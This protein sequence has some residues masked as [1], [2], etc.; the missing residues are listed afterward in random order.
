MCIRD[1][2]EPER[3]APTEAQ[4]ATPPGVPVAQLQKRLALITPKMCIRDRHY[5]DIHRL[6]GAGLEPVDVVT[7]GSP[8]QDYAEEI[9]I[10]K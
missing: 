7:F 4:P 8:C 3:E 6:S 9:V 1:R 10:P 2:A 5:G